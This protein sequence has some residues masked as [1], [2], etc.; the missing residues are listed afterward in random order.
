MDSGLV[1]F[2]RHGRVVAVGDVI[3]LAVQHGHARVRVLPVRVVSLDGSTGSPPMSVT[4][5][6]RV[7]GRA[8]LW[9]CAVTVRCDCCCDC[10]L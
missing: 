9:R 3:S 8:M 5:A 7:R 10:V 1:S 2:F 6:T 4:A